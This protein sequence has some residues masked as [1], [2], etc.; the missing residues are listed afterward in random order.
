[1]TIHH[2]SPIVLA[3]VLVGISALDSVTRVEAQRTQGSD[4][5]R[6]D[7]LKTC[8][9]GRYPSLCKRNLLTDAQR[10][11]AANTEGAENVKTCLT[12]RYPSLC[13]QNLLTEQQERQMVVAQVELARRAS[14]IYPGGSSTR[15]IMDLGGGD[16][17][18]LSTGEYIMHLGNGDRMNLNTGDY[19]MSLGGGDAINLGW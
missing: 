12:G 14:A 4:A 5:E 19:I 13:K 10:T 15:Y 8:L 11:Q 1:M 3:L 6:A 18:N 9:D 7:N 16:R 17:L 2:A